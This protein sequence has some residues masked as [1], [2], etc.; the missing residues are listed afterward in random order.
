MKQFKC[1]CPTH[2]CTTPTIYV[3]SK[4]GMAAADDDG[5]KCRTVA[6]AAREGWMWRQTM[7]DR[8]RERGGRQMTIPCDKPKIK[9]W[10]GGGVV[11]SLSHLSRWQRGSSSR[12]EVDAPAVVPSWKLL[13]P[14]RTLLYGVS[15]GCGIHVLALPPK[16]RHDTIYYSSCWA[17]PPPPPHLWWRLVG[18]SR[19]N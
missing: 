13:M 1:F 12:E 11:V 8:K 7:S 14:S 19:R 18:A 9:I 5:T 4:G 3:I 2:A 6:V 16:K 17:P 10:S 15:C